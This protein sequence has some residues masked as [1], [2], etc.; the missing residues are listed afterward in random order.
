MPW[1]EPAAGT[2]YLA[3]DIYGVPGTPNIWCVRYTIYI[4]GARHTMCMEPGTPSTSANSLGQ[5]KGSRDPIPSSIYIFSQAYHIY[6]TNQ[7]GWGKFL[8]PVIFL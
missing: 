7:R 3:H 1:L 4:Y 5:K 2:V 6:G 8:I